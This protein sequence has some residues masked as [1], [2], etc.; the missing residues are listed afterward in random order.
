MTVP[1]IFCIHDTNGNYWPNLAIAIKSVL[2]NSSQTHNL[3]VLH[4]ETISE[5]A[6]R[7][8]KM[9]CTK[10]SAGLNF[11]SVKIPAVINQNAFGHFSPASIFRIAIPQIFKNEEIVVYLDADLI[12][13]GVDITDIINSAPDAPIAAVLDPYIGRSTVHRDQLKTLSLNPSSYFNSGLLVMRPKKIKLNLMDSFID[14]LRKNPVLGHPDQ[15][16]LNFHFKDAWVQLDSRFNHQA[17][18]FERSLFMPLS[19]YWGKVI[20]YAGKIKPL[21]GYTAPAFIPFW[22]YASG[23]EKATQVF[24]A[25][26]LSLLEPDPSN[27]NNVIVRRYKRNAV[28]NKS[29]DI[30]TS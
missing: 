14:F 4:N 20:H 10:Y 15:D 27:V 29:A 12:F 9:I 16:F 11:V 8:I 2:V 13:H 28:S 23:L 3:Y 5:E 25:A 30:K 6:V 24:D 21:E 7:A 18:I 19:S 17:C 1:I 26:P 22:M